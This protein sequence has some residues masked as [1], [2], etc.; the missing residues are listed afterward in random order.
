MKRPKFTEA[1]I[2][3]ALKHVV[4]GS[5]VA[6]VCRKARIAKATVCHW[7]KKHE[8]RCRRRV[9]MTR[10]WSRRL[11][12]LEDRYSKLKRRVAGLSRKK[13]TLHPDPGLGVILLPL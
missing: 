9:A 2:A 13:V 5:S 6:G 12:M 1:R 4:D 8:G 7:R 11:K 10:H 3:F